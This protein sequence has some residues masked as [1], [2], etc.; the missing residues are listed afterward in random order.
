MP[1]SIILLICN[2]VIGLKNI[3]PVS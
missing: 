1:Y 3:A 2:A